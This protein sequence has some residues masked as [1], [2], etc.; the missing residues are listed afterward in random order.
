MDVLEAHAERAAGSD[1]G[2]VGSGIV[3]TPLSQAKLREADA[4]AR[5]ASDRI[6]PSA[7]SGQTSCRS[8]W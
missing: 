4:V 7:S 1:V 6:Q 2:S 5:W 3:S 8:S